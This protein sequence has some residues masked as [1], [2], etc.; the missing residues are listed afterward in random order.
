[1]FLPRVN[2]NGCDIGIAYECMDQ[3]GLKRLTDLMCWGDEHFQDWNLKIEQY[4]ET[5]EYFAC[6]R[7]VLRVVWMGLNDVTCYIMIYECHDSENKDFGS[8]SS[9][10][11]LNISGCTGDTFKIQQQILVTLLIL[12]SLPEKKAGLTS[13]FQSFDLRCVYTLIQFLL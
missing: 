5:F 7:E 6:T 2:D 8:Q 4:S 12:D 11:K 1:M 3:W 9:G 13:N 10:D